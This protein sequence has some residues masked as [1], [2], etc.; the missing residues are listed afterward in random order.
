MASARHPSQINLHEP[1]HRRVLL[2][3]RD[4]S[5]KRPR[6]AVCVCVWNVWIDDKLLFH[7]YL[8]HCRGPGA[9]RWHGPMKTHLCRRE[10]VPAIFQFPVY[11]NR[12][13]PEPEPTYYFILKSARV[14]GD[15]LSPEPDKPFL[16]GPFPVRFSR[17]GIFVV[18]F[19]PFFGSSH[20]HLSPTFSYEGMD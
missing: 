17:S 2:S 6:S 19:I 11:G 16:F 13:S 3:R 4:S 18:L 7:F 10:N 5:K 9:H 15:R 8:F 12:L 14:Y 1:V 20:A